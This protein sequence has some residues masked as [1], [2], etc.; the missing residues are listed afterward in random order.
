M[1]LYLSFIL[2]FY[3]GFRLLGQSLPANMYPDNQ[4][5]FIHGVASGDPTFSS[6]VIWTR[7][8]PESLSHTPTVFFE[9]SKDEAFQNIVKQGSFQT[10][11]S[12]D[13][14]VKIDVQNLETYKQYFYRFKDEQNRY[15]SIGRTRTTPKDTCSHLRIA[16]MSCSSVFSGFFNA[17][18][19]I[20]ESPDLDLVLHVGDY[21]YDFVDPDEKIRIPT[22]F[23]VDPKTLEEWR[24]RHKFYLL[25]PDLRE[26]R[27]VHPWVA[28]WDNHDVDFDDSDTLAPY[29]AFWEYL[30]IRMPD[31]NNSQK[32]YRKISFGNL[33][34]MFV[35]DVLTYRGQDT[36]SGS[37]TSLI[38]NSQYQW[39]T[40]ELSNSQAVWKLLPMQKLMCG[41]SIKGVPS[42]IGI[43]SG[44]VLD[45][46]NWDGYDAD[47]DRLLNY[48]AQNSIQNII[49]LSGDSHVTIFGDLSIDPYSSSVYN[50]TTGAG[51]LGVEMLPT[52]IS[53]GN[54]DEM[55]FGW[56]IP[57]IT[58]ILNNANPQHVFREL[59]SHGY[60]ILDIQPNRCIGEVW[61]SP[62]LNTSNQENYGKGFQVRK[63]ANHWD[64]TAL[65]SPTPPKDYSM[66]G[67]EF[68]FSKNTKP[69][70][71]KIYPNPAFQNLFVEFEAEINKWYEIQVYQYTGPST[72]IFK[73]V[74]SYQNASKVQLD[75]Q[76]LSSGIYLVT[77]KEKGTNRIASSFF[78]KP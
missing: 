38:G 65:S 77:V 13:W 47:R 17:Y 45:N 4:F 14:T 25:D 55:G 54:F 48:I 19:R 6:V 15:S 26:A 32:I 23:P 68:G 43:G 39:L 5:P 29:Q 70:P 61:Y 27:R 8:E 2:F 24:D 44:D 74:P 76:N 67:K 59:T 33:M 57:I 66:V 60:G 50:P 62:I 21:I 30:P 52:S 58:P 37:Q 12:K 78:L 18:K 20:A 63:D 56:A 3:L 72:S 71:L 16:I 1:K 41:W 35:T 7:I 22:P 34:E 51:S 75:I 49:A 73:E 46:K 40:Q 42:S 9:V 31:P 11:S 28:F 36:I 53:R 10:N 69:L 64:R